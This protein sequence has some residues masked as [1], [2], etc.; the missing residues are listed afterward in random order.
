MRRFQLRVV[1]GACLIVVSPVV[2]AQ[3]TM[4]SMFSHKK[5]LSPE[6]QSTP[7]EGID[8]SAK[9]APEVRSE[10]VK[11]L[12]P[13]TRTKTATPANA[14]AVLRAALASV[15]TGMT[16]VLIRASDWDKSDA[17]RGRAADEG[18]GAAAKPRRVSKATSTEAREVKSGGARW[19]YGPGNGPDTWDKLSSEFR[20]C[21]NGSMQSPI[22]I[23]ST[24]AIK[25]PEARPVFAYGPVGVRPGN[26]PA[27]QLKL[28]TQAGAVMKYKGDAYYL[29]SI[30][31]RLPGEGRVDGV[32][33][34]MSM[35]LHHRSAEGKHAIVSVPLEV[36]NEL[37]PAVDR[38]WGLIGQGAH[39]TTTVNPM[40]LLPAV[41]SHYH[42]IGSLT[43]PPCT[44]GVAWFVMRSPV[45]IARAQ[46]LAYSRAFAPNA[47]PAQPRKP[48]A[49]LSFAP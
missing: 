13:E 11:T 48:E 12:V 30:Q 14:E 18:S 36:A 39:A 4:P 33:S 25:T 21:R 7:S 17:T 28:L 23:W 32:A 16:E 46:F 47:R 44:E 42:Y 37:N 15:N 9:S 31:F 40:D 3:V 19:G 29:E 2:W 1:V 27:G 49:L 10:P 26:A 43:Q 35:Y 22:D 5:S 24:Q 45:S 8:Y 6:K 41:Q 20:A 34:V 38:L